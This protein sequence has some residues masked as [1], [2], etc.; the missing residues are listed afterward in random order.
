[1]AAVCQLVAV[2]RYS[3]SG[4]PGTI[5]GGEQKPSKLE[6]E[7]NQDHT[8]TVADDDRIPPIVVIYDVTRRRFLCRWSLQAD[9]IGSRPIF[10]PRVGDNSLT[11]ST[12]L[13]ASPA[14]QAEQ[15]RLVRIP[16]S[17]FLMDSDAHYPEERP[18]HRVRVDAFW[19]DERTVTDAQFAVALDE[20]GVLAPPGRPRQFDRR[21]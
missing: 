18:Q 8:T 12:V 13:A 17:A 6:P 21:A 10:H 19:T 20:R 7:E 5:L 4:L 11:A 2:G 9:S 1:V 14:K 3:S 16:G 15:P